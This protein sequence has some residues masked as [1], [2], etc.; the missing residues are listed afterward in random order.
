[1][2]FVHS[3]NGDYNGTVW[4]DGLVA[5]KISDC[6]RNQGGRSDIDLKW[7]AYDSMPNKKELK[8]VQ[9]TSPVHWMTTLTEDIERKLVVRAQK[10]TI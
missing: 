6:D 8:L 3:V 4:R 9:G 10:A 2:E 7:L 1:M 5:F